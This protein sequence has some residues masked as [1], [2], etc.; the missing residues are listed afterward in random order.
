[1]HA[2]EDYAG[3]G[4]LV[5]DLARGFDAVEQRHGDVQH[6]YIG[7]MLLGQGHG[8]AAVRSFRYHL[9]SGLAFEQ[10]AE[11]AADDLMIVG[12]QNADRAHAA[13]HPLRRGSMIEMVVP[14]PGWASTEKVPPRLAAR[15]SMPSKPMPRSRSGWKPLPSS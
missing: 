8:F 14:R 11:A 4:N 3:L 6:R 2:E 5:A 10:K 9:K 15:S 1:M 7:R 12:Q 13:P